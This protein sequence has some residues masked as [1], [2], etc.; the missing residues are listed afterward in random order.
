MY[1][2]ATKG[3]NRACLKHER[4]LCG[5]AV[6]FAEASKWIRIGPAARQMIVLEFRRCMLAEIPANAQAG[7]ISAAYHRAVRGIAVDRF[8]DRCVYVGI[9]EVF[10]FS[11]MYV[12]IARAAGSSFSFADSL[13][14]SLFIPFF[15][16][17]LPKLLA[18]KLL[19]GL[20]CT[21]VVTLGAGTIINY[22]RRQLEPLR[23]AGR[24]LSLRLGDEAV[25]QKYAA[26]QQ[27]IEASNVAKAQT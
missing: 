2:A 6:G 9:A 7:A 15:V 3:R 10:I 14:T 8:I 27:K 13:I 16:T 19:G 11:F 5:E 4:E 24:A 26:L 17:D 23:A 18:L 20:Q 22:F 25:R 12:G 1:R 21:L